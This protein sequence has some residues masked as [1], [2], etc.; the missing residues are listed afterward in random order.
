M[1]E[2]KPNIQ[3][4]ANNHLCRPPLLG[5]RPQNALPR[6]PADADIYR[7]TAE[8]LLEVVMLTGGQYQVLGA[9]VG[10]KQNHTKPHPPLVVRNIRSKVPVPGYQHNPRPAPAVNVSKS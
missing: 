5:C 4:S 6:E 9:V 3:M 1:L 7:D 8:Q 2:E 10:V